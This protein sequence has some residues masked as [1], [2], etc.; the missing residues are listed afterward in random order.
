MRG[1]KGKVVGQSTSGIAEVQAEAHRLPRRAAGSQ[2]SEDVNR[3]AKVLVER[4]RKTEIQE[5]T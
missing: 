4:T 5:R 3:G 2:H 1:G